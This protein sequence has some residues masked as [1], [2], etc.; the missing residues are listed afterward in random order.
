MIK[1]EIK[2]E[3]LAFQLFPLFYEGTF[4]F[5]RR[6]LDTP[7][8]LGTKNNT[9][10]FFDLENIPE[11]FNVEFPGEFSE[12][13]AVLSSLEYLLRR[14]AMEPDL[15]VKDFI[16]GNAEPELKQDI[17]KTINNFISSHNT[18]TEFLEKIKFQS[19]T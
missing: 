12:V 16:K 18:S 1:L 15:K 13:Q 11:A 17:L 8:L 14:I 9:I 5:G 2:K 10:Q 7:G 4:I 19:S 6:L 3:D